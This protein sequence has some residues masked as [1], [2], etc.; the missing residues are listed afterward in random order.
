MR[1]IVRCSNKSCV[2]NNQN[3]LAIGLASTCKYNALFKVYISYMFT[4]SPLKCVL[5]HTIKYKLI[6]CSWT[7]VG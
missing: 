5:A 2:E 1:I 6:H 3:K 4:N 7:V